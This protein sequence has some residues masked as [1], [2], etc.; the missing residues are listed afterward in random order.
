MEVLIG[1]DNTDDMQSIKEFLYSFE[2][3]NIGQEIAEIAIE[4]RKKYRLKLPDALILA[5][6]KISNALLVTR[7]IRDFPI[8]LPIIRM[9]YRL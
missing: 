1:V 3:I 9:P 2:I 5:T 8:D 7:D 6:A 4:E